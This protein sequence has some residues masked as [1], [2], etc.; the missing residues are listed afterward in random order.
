[1]KILPDVFKHASDAYGDQLS[2]LTRPS[3]KQPFDGPTWK[4][5]YE[6]GLNLAT[7]LAELGVKNG[8][9]IA[10]LADNRFE[11]ILSDYA[12]LMNG[13]VSIPRATSIMDDEL[14]YIVNHSKSTVV[15]VEHEKMLKRLIKLKEYFPNVR[16]LIVMDKKYQ[17][18]DAQSIAD[19]VK[20]GEKSRSQGNQIINDRLKQIKEDD[21]FT[22][23]YTS[24]TTG[25]PKGVMLTHANMV[26][27]IKQTGDIMQMSPTD[28][29]VTI[30]PIWHVFERANEYVFISAG[31]ATYYSNIRALAND[32]KEVQPTLMGSAP[33]LWESIYDKIIAKVKAGSAVKK[34]LF[35]LAML[36][37]SQVN[38]AQRFFSSLIATTTNQSLISKVILSFKYSSLWIICFIP[39]NAL[40]FIPA[41]LRLSTGGKLRASLSAGGALPKH[42]DLFFNNI[43]ISL[44]EGYGMTECC[45]AIAMRTPLFNVIGSVGK[46][47]PDCQIEIRD[48]NQ[49]DKVMPNG[50]NGVVF[51]KGPQVMKG[52]YENESATTKTI[53]NGWLDTGDIGVINTNGSLSITGR[54]KETIVLLSGENVEPVPIENKLIESSYIAQIMVVGQ[55][56]KNLA[57]LI[58]LDE[59]ILLDWTQKNQ[60]EQ[61]QISELKLNDQVNEL[62]RTEIQQQISKKNGFQSFEKIVSFQIIDKAFAVDDELTKLFKIKRHVV[63][64]KYADLILAMYQ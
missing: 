50:E 1:M 42:I 8:D 40:S 30:L 36:T 60:I 54:S 24:D 37:N 63:N 18:T 31:A 14:K 52:Y 47:L 5:L 46:P 29:A 27:M 59:D 51:V 49:P 6:M 33:R 38:E 55:D 34:S 16:Q 15:I 13:A 64:E 61:N 45:P 32:L 57:A 44:L 28:R 39:S 43:G 3:L 20:S 62:I 25:E 9:H 58:V 4:Q 7:A 22:I 56:Q 10:V 11:W 19:L 12:I 2:F 23:I 17:G 48:L 41:K 35:K 21:V 26:Y 53:V